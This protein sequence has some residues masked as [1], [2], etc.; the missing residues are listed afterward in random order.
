[1]NRVTRPNITG[2][3][4]GDRFNAC[5]LD[6]CSGRGARTTLAQSPGSCAS[7]PGCPGASPSKSDT[8]RPVRCCPVGYQV[9]SP[10]L[11]SALIAYSRRKSDR[12]RPRSRA[13][14]A[15]IW[16]LAPPD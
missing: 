12:R 2:T 6:T 15:L 4:L 1:M 14:R 11:V 10:T 16:L 9:L 8:S 3:D 5:F 13:H 7:S